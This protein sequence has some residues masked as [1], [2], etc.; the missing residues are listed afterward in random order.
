[1]IQWIL[2]QREMQLRF[3]PESTLFLL[4][5]QAYSSGNW[6]YL[7]NWK[8][9][10]VWSHFSHLMVTGITSPGC[11]PVRWYMMASCSP[12]Y[13]RPPPLSL[14]LGSTDPI[15][16]NTKVQK[17]PEKLS[18]LTAKRIWVPTPDFLSGF[19]SI[20]YSVFG[21]GRNL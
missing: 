10:P 5:F 7:A 1:M 2:I 14:S 12:D 18:V 15:Q 13:I 17:L 4:R 20:A 6:K 19:T 21:D 9:P 3:L 11:R 16:R 8:Y